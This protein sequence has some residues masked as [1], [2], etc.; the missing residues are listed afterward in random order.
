CRGGHRRRER[1]ARQHPPRD[2]R[3]QLRRDHPGARGC[4]SRRAPRCAGG[5]HRDPRVNGRRCALLVFLIACGA[6]AESTPACGEDVPLVSCET[7]TQ[8]FLSTH[9]QGC[10]ASTTPDRQGAPD[11][12]TFD[13]EESAIALGEAIRR[14]AA[15]DAPTMPPN[16][17]PSAEDRHKLELWVT[18]FAAAE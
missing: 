11:G 13:T 4:G 5:H 6:E 7:F 17:G 9:C 10:H 14:V 18:C 8:G 16:G 3:E 12:V 2:R 15:S 1:R